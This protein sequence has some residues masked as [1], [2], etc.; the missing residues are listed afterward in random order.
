MFTLQM[1]SFRVN[2]HASPVFV[3]RF[4]A[5]FTLLFFIIFSNLLEMSCCL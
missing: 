3:I 5:E 4:S 2:T 1:D